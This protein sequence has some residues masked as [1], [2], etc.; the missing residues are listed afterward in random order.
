MVNASNYFANIGGKSLLIT[1]KPTSTVTN[2]SAAGT[3]STNQSIVLQT[4]GA[5]NGA[6]YILGSQG[7]PLKVQGNIITQVSNWNFIF[8]IRLLKITT[9]N[10]GPMFDS[11]LGY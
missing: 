6:S 8:S 5:P 10:W 4:S 1:G 2:T 9:E 11:C 3:T 7:Q